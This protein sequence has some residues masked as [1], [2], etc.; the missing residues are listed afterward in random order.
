M[1]LSDI[2]DIGINPEE[3]RHGFG[4]KMNI[5]VIGLGTVGSELAEYD[6]FAG[7][8]H[9]DYD[10][11]ALLGVDVVVNAAGVAGYSVCERAGFDEVMR[12]NVGFPLEVQADCILAKVPLVQLSTAG[13][14]RTQVCENRD[15]VCASENFPVY[16]HNLSCASEILKCTHLMER[17]DEGAGTYIL[18]MPWFVSDKKME[19][20]VK[21][22][23]YVQRTWTSILEPIDLAKTIKRIGLSTFEPGIYNIGSKTVY[24]PDFVRVYTDRKIPV[25]SGFRQNMTSAIPLD[26]SKAVRERLLRDDFNDGQ[27]I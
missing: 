16:P 21:T 3:E 10:A 17:K 20:L 26:V 6:S 22:F 24:F 15:D 11:S 9:D 12:G 18:R 4:Q 13:V 19:M 27:R 14:Y 23:S 1:E 8:S 5:L 2:L 7:I 25:R